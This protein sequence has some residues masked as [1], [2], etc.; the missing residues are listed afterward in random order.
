MTASSNNLFVV[1]DNPHLGTDGL[2]KHYYSSHTL[3]IVQL[4]KVR[5]L[6]RSAAT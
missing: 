5:N 3:F 4:V 6:K 1:D 2:A